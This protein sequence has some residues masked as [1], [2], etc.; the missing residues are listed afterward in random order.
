MEG[1]KGTDEDFRP[2]EG[3]KGTDL[4]SRPLEETK[5]LTMTSGLWKKQ[6]C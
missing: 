6:V 1:N 2:L 5:V 3:N 4:E